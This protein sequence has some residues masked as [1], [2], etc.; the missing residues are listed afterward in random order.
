MTALTAK[1][2]IR[3]EYGD[4]KNFMT[5]KVLSVGKAGT[6][7]AWELSTGPGIFG[8]QI[9]GVSVVDYNPETEQTT[10]RPDLSESYQRRELAVNHIDALEPLN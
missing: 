2:I 7:R 10:R 3:K 6:R 8:D 1:Q 5:P 9:W 4:G